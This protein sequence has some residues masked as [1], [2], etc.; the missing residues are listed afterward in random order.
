[1]NGGEHGKRVLICLV[2]ILF[3][4]QTRDQFQTETCL[5]FVSLYRHSGRLFLRL[6]GLQAQTEAMHL[7]CV[8][9]V[10]LDVDGRTESHRWSSV[11]DPFVFVD[12]M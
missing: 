8:S 2:F 4:V 1:M 5:L 12:L 3:W 11:F 7:L 10:R 6:D 9:E